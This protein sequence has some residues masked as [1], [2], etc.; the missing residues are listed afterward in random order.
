MKANENETIRTIAGF[1]K[2]MRRRK[3][4]KLKGQEV[5]IYPFIYITCVFILS[6]VTSHPFSP[7]LISPNPLPPTLPFFPLSY[8]FS[9]SLQKK[10][11]LAGMLTKHGI[12]SYSKSMHKL[13]YQDRI[14]PPIR[15]KRVLSTGKRGIGSF[16]PLSQTHNYS[17]NAQDQPQTSSGSA[18]VT[19][20]SVNPDEHSLVDS[21]GHVLVDSF[22]YLAPTIL[23]P[24]LLCG[25]PRL[26]S[27][28]IHE[29]RICSHQLLL[30][31]LLY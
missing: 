7:F 17:L 21:V 24:Q 9:V 11:G 20:V 14:S 19:S 1:R 27:I 15:N 29:P 30:K 22:T 2:D 31:P 23:L 16:T 28:I 12:V 6:Y 26:C 4:R 10:A 3:S 18:F 25:F 5:L 13:L 8:F